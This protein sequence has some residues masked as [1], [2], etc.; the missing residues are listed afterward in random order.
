MKMCGSTSTASDSKMTFKTP[1]KFVNLKMGSKNHISSEKPKKMKAPKTL[2]NDPQLSVKVFCNVCDKVF[3]MS[4]L[5]KHVASRHSLNMTNYKKIYGDPRKQ[6]IQL[7]YHPC[8]LCKKVMLFDTVDISKHVTKK[9]SLLFNVYSKLHMEKGSGIIKKSKPSES[10]IPVKP[11]PS[12]AHKKKIT[13]APNPSNVNA[14]L[15]AKKSQITRTN[16]VAPKTPASNK[17]QTEKKTQ[18][19]KKSEK[20]PAWRAHNSKLLSPKPK[21]GV[22]KAKTVAK[23]PRSNRSNNSKVLSP[24]PD[25]KKTKPAPASKPASP[26]LPPTPPAT[27][28]FIKSEQTEINVPITNTNLVIIKCDVCFKQFSKNIQLKAHMKK[29]HS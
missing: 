3:Q 23:D 27:P 12:G 15:M 5:R 21:S 6:I 29:N 8:N 2:S 1:A 16:S 25:T 19:V 9:H 14:S 26:V 13:L 20:P 4:G 11:I 24:K 7:I 17:V 10:S 18:T 28:P 22:T